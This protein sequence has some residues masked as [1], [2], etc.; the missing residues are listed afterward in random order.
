MEEYGIELIYLK[1]T[2]NVAADALSRLPR[3]KIAEE[4]NIIE[5]SDCYNVDALPVDAFPIRYN[6]IHIEQQL[7]KALVRRVDNPN[8]L[9]LQPFVGGGTVRADLQRGWKD[10]CAVTP[11]EQGFNL[12]SLAPD[13]SRTRQI[14]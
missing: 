7:D 10:N 2:H 11:A 3:E 9:T 5:A 14:I 4:S 12:A 6:V 8:D 1:G 13:A